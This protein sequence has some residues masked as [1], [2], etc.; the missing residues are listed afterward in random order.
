MT[1]EIEMSIAI[2]RLNKGMSAWDTKLL[3]GREKCVKP[4]VETAGMSH[5]CYV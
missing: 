5:V 2:D 1:P 4:K 3:A